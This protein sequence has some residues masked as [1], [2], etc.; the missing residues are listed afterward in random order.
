[1]PRS[2]R[3]IVGLGNPGVKYEGTRHNIGFVVVNAL[4][5]QTGVALSAGRFNALEGWGR[6]AD[7]PFGLALPIT[8]V[9][10]S[11][12]AVK[13]LVQY[14]N[15]EPAGLLVVVDDVHLD[16]GALRLRPGGGSGGHNGL[17]HIAQVL[18]TTDFPRLRIGIGKNYRKG[19]QAE[20]VLSRFTPEQKPAINAAIDRACEAA[21]TFIS[22]GIEAAMN[23]YN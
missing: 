4:A 9:N 19:E 16:T 6:H 15:I 11:G 7:R 8:Y 12:E 10:R 1:M 2:K 3:L 13:P 21:L 18:G 17:K 20:Y 14:N 5:E 22:S 23:Q